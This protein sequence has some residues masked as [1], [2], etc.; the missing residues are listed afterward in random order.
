MTTSS[1]PAVSG[2]ELPWREQKKLL[3]RQALHDAAR[4]SVLEKG[5]GA[6]TVEEICAA[7]GVS[8]RTFFNYF[9]SKAAATLGLPDVQLTGDQRD[10][11]RAS[12]GNLVRDLCLLV[13]SAFDAAGEELSDK[14]TRRDI[15]RLR[16]E[17]QQELSHW[18]LTLRGMLL[19]AVEERASAVAA[20]R[21]L[22][23][24]FAALHSVVESGNSSPSGLGRR[25]WT[26]VT[27]MCAL[28]DGV[29]QGSIDAVAAVG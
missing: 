3:T 17:L 19:D 29:Q 20:R 26:E 25:L 11:F 2:A 9:P 13:G 21:A 14:S 4:T 6:V 5:L 22:A 1:A 10:A 7:A 27:Q 28:T 24:V 23:L 16:P 18:M 12:T 8:P 15:V